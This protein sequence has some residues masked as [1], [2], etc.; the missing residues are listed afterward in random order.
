MGEDSEK[1]DR[2]SG[3]AAMMRVTD[4]DMAAGLLVLREVSVPLFDQTKPRCV[5]ALDEL[6]S[7]IRHAPGYATSAER[8]RISLEWGSESST[9]VLSGLKGFVPGRHMIADEPAHQFFLAYDGPFQEAC[10]ETI[11]RK[12]C[13]PQIIE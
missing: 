2:A 1:A 12:L 11:A 6:L 5:E 8:L 7:L 10:S 4:P 9:K 13:E 3:G